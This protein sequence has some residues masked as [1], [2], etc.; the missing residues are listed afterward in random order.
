MS[1]PNE[2]TDLQ[3]IREALRL[4][5]R[6]G[7]TVELRI[8]NSGKGTASG[9]FDNLDAAAKAAVAWSGKVP[10]VYF[11]I[12]PV[13]PALLARAKNRLEEYARST[14]GDVDIVERRWF[15]LDID[16]VRPAGISS[17][18]EEHQ[19]ALVRASAI[20]EWLTGKGWP[21]PILGD[22]GNGGHLCHP[23]EL[24]NDVPTTQLLQR[25]LQALDLLFSDDRVVADTSTYNAARIWKLYGTVVCKGDSIVDRPHR[26][27]RIL[28]VPQ[29][30]EPVP[31]E[32]LQAL[33]NM[34]PQSPQR[35]PREPYEG[36]AFDLERWIAD[37]GLEVA[38]VAPWQGGRKWVLSVCPWNA[39]HRNRSA[40]IVQFLS[41]AIAAGC[42]HN[43][44]QGKGWP[45]LRDVVEPGWRDKGGKGRMH[46]P[47]EK[48]GT[49]R[50]KHSHADRLLQLV[51]ESRALL[52]TDQQGEGYVAPEGDGTVVHR[53]DS[54]ATR[55]WL[56]RLLYT[57]AGKAPSGEA[58]QTA[59]LTLEAIAGAEGPRIPLEVRVAWQNG[60][61]WYDLG[62]EA[63][64][65]ENID[66]QLIES[67]PVL[68]A[69]F[70]HQVPQVKPESGDFNA[71]DAFLPCGGEAALLLKVW[72]LAA[73]VPDGPRPLLDLGGPQGSGKST[74]AKVLK[75]LIDPSIVLTIR[76]IP[77]AKELSQILA[78]NWAVFFD[79][80]GHLSA[81]ASDAFSAA[82]SGDGDLRRKLYTDSDTV[83]FIYRRVV[84]LNSISHTAQRPDLLDRTLLITLQ[85]ISPEA[86]EDEAAFWGRFNAALPSILGGAFDILVRAIALRPMVK[87]ASKP[88]MADFAAWGYAIA[89]AAGWGGAR[90]LAAYE[91]N[92]GRQHEEAVA[93]S[94]VA[95]AIIAFMES[96]GAWEGPASALKITLD[97][98]AEQQGIDLKSRWS[99][100]PADAP[101]LSKEVRR[102][103]E[104]L[105]ASGIEVSYGFQKK[106]RSIRLRKIIIRLEGKTTVGTV[107][108]VGAATQPTD[109]KLSSA[110]GKPLVTDGKHAAIP[111]YA[112]ATDGTDSK[113]QPLSGDVLEI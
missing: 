99:G 39:E 24:P 79:N 61:V 33:A 22:S 57:A 75:R 1:R 102:L 81:D 44:C 54:R 29:R 62:G 48:A 31:R 94:V 5:I 17:T 35:Q 50:G 30:L 74:T 4:F 96:R 43:S 59:I 97:P 3:H 76:R 90:F 56:S 80:I 83:A 66:W 64:R 45:E 34:V 60:A 53:L 111:I 113:N 9:Y 25:C 103:A 36:D 100:W 78:Q 63:V 89:E 55:R 93:A 20:R 10:A 98:V 108:A 6:E 71:I 52:F 23:V 92:V 65:I 105:G 104:T 14:T 13:N 70:L 109:S 86:R 26:R 7:D 107:G 40:Y 28:D 69:R 38:T 95:Q 84:S 112:D 46:K 77:D 110:D 16:P 15:P 37:H 101:R 51:R 85:R 47:R 73:L 32:L 58:L 2:S 12:N 8:P 11:T 68:F 18:D 19:A 88:R 41:G 91:R 67:P 106:T 82:V 27:A 49:Q 42:H 72:A 87:L 21:R